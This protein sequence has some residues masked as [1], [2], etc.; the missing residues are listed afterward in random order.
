MFV[1][2]G[3]FNLLRGHYKISESADRI[4]KISFYWVVPNER[5]SVWKD[6]ASRKIGPKPKEEK[7]K[8]KLERTE[9]ATCLNKYIDQYI[10]VMD[11]IPIDYSNNGLDEVTDSKEHFLFHDG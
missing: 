5:E 2:S 11:N 10:L 1:A 9:L 6:K 8:E 3:H 7:P 4:G